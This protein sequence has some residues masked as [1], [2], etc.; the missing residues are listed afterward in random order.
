MVVAYA[1]QHVLERTIDLDVIARAKK[2]G[3]VIAQLQRESNILDALIHPS[4]PLEHIAARK[5]EIEELFTQLDE[6][7]Q[8]ANKVTY[9]TMQVWG[10]IV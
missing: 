9:A 2:L 4:T 1:F 5:D 6:L 7:E 3:V 10:N 8:D